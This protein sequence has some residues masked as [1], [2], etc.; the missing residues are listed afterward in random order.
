MSNF[1][2]CER[3]IPEDESLVEVIVLEGDEPTIMEFKNGKFIH[4]PACASISPR[5]VHS[6]RYTQ[7]LEG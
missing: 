7:I 6:W 3:A 5:F 2:L 4:Q 1:I